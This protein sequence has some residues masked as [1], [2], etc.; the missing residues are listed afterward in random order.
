MADYRF[1]RTDK[2][3]RQAFLEQLT[4]HDFMTLTIAQIAKASLID[5]STFYAHYDSLYDL[6]VSVIQDELR[7]LSDSLATTLANRK[8][9][10]F[11]TYDFFNHAV[12]NQLNREA[13]NIQ[14]LRLISLGEQGFDNQ[15]KQ[16]FADY[17]QQIFTVQPNSYMLFLLINIAM[18]DLD[19]ILINHQAPSRHDLTSSLQR[20]LKAS[21][22]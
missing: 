13:A 22:L 17:Y 18:S 20:I 2:L 19:Y 4:H 8:S 10:Q 21:P 9:D 6:A 5:R 3:I 7:L 1:Q 16:I 14:Q 12:L 15:C 11:N